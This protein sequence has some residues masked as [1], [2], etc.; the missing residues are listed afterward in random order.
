MKWRVI[1]V[2]TM[3]CFISF[4]AAAGDRTEAEK[5][6][7]AVLSSFHQAASDADGDLYFGHLVEGAVFMGTDA[8][9]RWS[10]EELEAFARPYFSEGRGWTYTKT[11]RHVYVAA[12]GLTA[13]FD[14]MLWNETYGNCRGTG[15]LVRT[16]NGWR[17]AQ[18]SL[19]IP[20]PND[21]ARDF[22]RQI[23]DLK[24]KKD[25]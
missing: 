22:T 23:R 21:L 1:L 3:G 5:A 25:R 12:D 6:V 7:D 19:S 4:S 10:V 11:Q 17:I 13:W 15:V 2:V 8:T 9:E 18:Y 16:D 14:E 24:T 20:I